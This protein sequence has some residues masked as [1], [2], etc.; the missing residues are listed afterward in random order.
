M[1]GRREL[2]VVMEGRRAGTLEELQGRLRLSYDDE[3]RADPTST[4]LSVSLP[5]ELAG[6]PHA[7]V[8]PWLW[9]LL[10]DNPD[11]L[12]RWGRSY[13]VS[14]SSAFRLLATPIG[15][16]CPGAV[17]F[18]DPGRA[19]PQTLATGAIEWLTDEEVAA[20]IA[21]LRRDTTAWL[22]ARSTGQ[23]SLAG[24]QAKT[25]LRFDPH[26]GWGRPTGAEPTNRILKP[27]SVGFADLAVN[28]HL[29]LTLARRLGLPAA[30][31]ELRLFDA[32]LALV[33]ERYDRIEQDG[34]LR[35]VH[36]ED[37]CQAL[38]VYPADKY[39][40]D[41]GPSVE[42]VI[43]LLRRVLP[44][45]TVEKE[46]WRFVDAL[47]LN[48]LIGGT[49]AHAKNHGLLLAGREVRLAPLYDVA[50]MLPYEP[51]PLQLRMAMRIGGEYRC[52]AITKRSWLKLAD[53]NQLDAERLVERARVLA[54][55][56]GELLPGL[57]AEV[58]DA[59]G[60]GLPALLAERG[61]RWSSR[62]LATW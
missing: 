30:R 38:S 42:D 5:P 47:L 27:S 36:Q 37:L 50:S 13:G 8:D 24:A 6:H 11:V 52:K 57:A 55:S 17:R 61:E 43:A 40:P 39:Q 18:V 10:P 29:C 35:R 48:W 60:S 58:A 3:W 53:T 19:H 28:E 23:F 33:V 7:R 16:D 54:A 26:R 14:A 22:G 49:D 4:P 45:Q 59:T 1:T 62:C 2:A 20:E 15:M 12:R 25:A 51:D 34:K 21:A 41:G 46:V 31:S 56:I 9:G 32:E 44:P